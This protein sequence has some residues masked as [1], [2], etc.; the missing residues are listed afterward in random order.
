MSNFYSYQ[1]QLIPV[2]TWYEGQE[3]LTILPFG[4]KITSTF[5]KFM[6]ELFVNPRIGFWW[7]GQ[8]ISV[9]NCEH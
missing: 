4:N 7:S 5:E 9:C 6:H 1:L 8:G 2:S 3:N